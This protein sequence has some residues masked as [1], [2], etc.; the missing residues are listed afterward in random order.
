[1]SPLS[2]RL[3][4]LVGLAG[5][6]MAV[7]LLIT[8]T[9]TRSE[10]FVAAR[11]GQYTEGVAGPPQAINP[12]LASDDAATSIAALVF[13]GLTRTGDA[14]ELVP[15]LA[16]RWETSPDGKTYTFFLRRNVTWHDGA[17]FT[18]EDVVFTINAIK[19]AE[20][21]GPLQQ[22]WRNVAVEQVD[23]YTVR[24]TL[25]RDPFAPFLEYTTTGILPA[26]LLRSVPARQLPFESF[27]RAP[28]GTGPYRV[29]DASAEAITLEAFPGYY[30]PK[31]FIARLRFRFYPNPQAVSAALERGEV[32]GAYY[33]PPDEVATLRQSGRVAIYSAQMASYTLIFLNLSRPIF[34]EK[35]V[36]QALAYG[37]DRQQLIDRFRHGQALKADSPILPTSWAYHAGI[38]RYEYN[39]ELARQLLDR[40]RWVPGTD[41][42]REKDGKRLSFVLLT[43]DSE[44]RERVRMA[45]EIA[46]QLRE[47][48]VQVE[49]QA[50]GVGGLVQEFLLARR[51]D[52]ALYSWDLNGYD[53]DP[54]PLWHSSQA[55]GN[56]LNLS[57]FNHR[58]A[59]ELLETA[60]RTLDQGQ[61][62][63]LYIEFQ[64]IFAEEVPSILLY[65]PVYNYAVSTKVKGIRLGLM[66]DVAD[67]FR[68]IDRWYILTR[69]A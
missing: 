11:G 14:G 9:L 8:S 56:G 42:I 36:R 38:K 55:T 20:Y 62:R 33:V 40:A 39:P 10:P 44:T 49:V 69:R 5:A 12:I 34:Q 66:L 48:G 68:G 52:A 29:R 17:P 24:F 53:P 18:A 67:R 3:H 1:L 4:W 23:D 63:Q 6:V 47:I 35:A 54:Y 19:D 61:R 25:E 64:D 60:R 51:F 27:N 57:G 22:L 28:V 65:Y 59:D 13:S 26:H 21:Q 7:A 31:P 58:R 41:G 15:D 37:I 30:G 50:A 46:R 16:E 32:E 43:N 45:E 2:F